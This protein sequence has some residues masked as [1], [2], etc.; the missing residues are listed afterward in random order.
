MNGSV[1]MRIPAG[2]A[3]GRTMRLGGQGMPRLRGT[4]RGDL[5][6]TLNALLPSSLTDE[7]KGLFQQLQQAGL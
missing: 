4:E 6:V 2:S 7:Q 1:T 3:N 5:Y